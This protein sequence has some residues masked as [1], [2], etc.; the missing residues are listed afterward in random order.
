MD[1]TMAAK[2]K[3]PKAT[4]ATPDVLALLRTKYPLPEWVSAAEVRNSTGFGASRSCDFMA[5]QTWPSKGLYLHGHEIKVHR[6]DWLREIQDP[7][8]AAAFQQR[9]HFWWIVATPGVVNPEEVPGSW[10]LMVATE[11]TLRVKKAAQINTPID[12]DYPFVAAMLRGMPT[13]TSASC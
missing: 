10:G 9:C 11:K 8:K 4:A 7:T 2:A 3:K 12:L 5:M 13:G 1:T 6:S